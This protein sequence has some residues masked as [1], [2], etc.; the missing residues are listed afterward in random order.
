MCSVGVDCLYLFFQEDLVV[1]WAL[2]LILSKFVDAGL[3]PVMCG[4][5]FGSSFLAISS[6]DSDIYLLGTFS[7]IIF[8]SLVYVAFIAIVLRLHI[9]ALNYFN[10]LCKFPLRKHVHHL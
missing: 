9:M 10:N 6:I 2:L 7:V 1:L 5:I 4:R 8:R 3:D